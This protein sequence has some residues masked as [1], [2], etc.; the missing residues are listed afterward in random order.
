MEG[1]DVT[2]ATRADAEEYIAGAI[3]SDELVTR[4]RA[5]HGLR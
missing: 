4:A 1:V 3:T 5:R 2:P